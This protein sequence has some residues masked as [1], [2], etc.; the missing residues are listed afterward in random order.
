MFLK[1]H[2]VVRTVTQEERDSG[3]S[4]SAVFSAAAAA[5]A[6]KSRREQ[7][8]LMHMGKTLG[9]YDSEE[10][11][12]ARLGAR[13]GSSCDG[14]GANPFYLRARRRESDDQSGGRDAKK[15]FSLDNQRPKI[16]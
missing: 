1:Q 9:T 15:K 5:A 12:A 6:F 7:G 14:A 4:V 3:A 2:K 8:A 10:G 13:R 11:H 16:Y